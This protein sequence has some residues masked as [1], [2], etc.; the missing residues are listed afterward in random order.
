[1]KCLKT[2]EIP[3]TKTRQHQDHGS[4]ELLLGFEYAYTSSITA[5]GRLP[6][7]RTSEETQ[8]RKNISLPVTLIFTFR[9]FCIC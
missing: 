9:T 8:E 6:V 1:M 7:I 3:K 5:A 4:A 2:F